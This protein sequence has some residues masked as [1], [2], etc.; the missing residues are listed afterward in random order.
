M[1]SNMLCLRILLPWVPSR[2]RPMPQPTPEQ[3]KILVDPSRGRIVRAA[4][5]S[6]KTWLIAEEIR[7]RMND[8]PSKHAGI[9]ALSFTNVAR[10]EINGSVGSG[11]Q[12]PHFVGT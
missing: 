5:G 3:Q 8:W 7:R 11:L 2:V 6:G 4:P 9:A 10:D 1:Q 12:H